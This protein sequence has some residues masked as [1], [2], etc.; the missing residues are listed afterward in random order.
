MFKKIAV[1]FDESSEAERAFRAAIDLAKVTSGELYIVTVI[2]NLPA[3][4]NYVSA[5]APEV[6]G[7][8]KNERRTFYED[9]HKKAKTA[10]EQAGIHLHTEIVEGDEIQALLQ[11]LD[12]LRPDL[13]VVGLRLEP[14]G[15][16]NL[17]GGTAHRLALHARCNVLG[18]R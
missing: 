3:Y 13:L 8:L 17:V 5:V 2:E 9:L 18:I 6:P 16:S 11:V 15:L 12:R 4:I 1:A 14:G 7:L 10:A